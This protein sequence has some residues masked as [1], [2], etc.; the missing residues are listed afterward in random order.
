MPIHFGDY[1]GFLIR[2][3]SVTREILNF[4]MQFSGFKSVHIFNVSSESSLYGHLREFGFL[5][6]KVVDTL[7][8]EFESMS[9]D[10]FLSTLSKNTRQSYR[11]RLRRLKKQGRIELLKI[12]ERRGYEENFHH[13][14]RLYDL[15]WRGGTRPLLDDDYYRM[16]NAALGPL[17]DAGLVVL[18]LVS[19]DGKVIAFRLGFLHKHTFYDWKA[20]HDPNYD[21]YSPGFLSIGLIIES[22]IDDGYRRLNFMAGDYPY[23]RSWTNCSDY[24]HNSEFVSYKRHSVGFF[25]AKY[26]ISVRERLKGLVRML[27]FKK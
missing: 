19:L 6:R 10:R 24:S 25:F 4:I 12:T 15:R 16:R 9:F 1:Y 2:D 21:Y 17:F 3:D 23:K 5:E 7:A 27:G 22:L 8:P 13:T 26:V 20:S 11:K 18:Y 14:R